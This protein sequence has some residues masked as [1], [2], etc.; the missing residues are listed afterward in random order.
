MEELIKLREEIVK[1]IKRTFLP[2]DL[3]S[4]ETLDK[5]DC[6]LWLVRRQIEGVK[7]VDLEGVNR[8]DILFEN[9]WI[10]YLSHVAVT[11]M[12]REVKKEIDAY[13]KYKRESKEL[14][15]NPRFFDLLDRFE[16]F[17]ADPQQINIK[18]LFEKRA[19]LTLENLLDAAKATQ[20]FIM[21]TLKYLVLFR[22]F[23]TKC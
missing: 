3:S 11:Y 8:G 14:K 1:A 2:L 9:I 18:T 6:K 13:E 17:E 5:L 23:V 15:V 21:D 22:N 12:L 19:D 4:F 7:C 10:I 16:I 20:D